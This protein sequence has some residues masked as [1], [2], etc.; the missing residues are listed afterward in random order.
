MK[1]RNLI[2]PREQRREQ[3]KIYDF[4][5]GL[6]IDFMHFVSKQKDDDPE[7]DKKADAKF[8]YCNLKWKNK[9]HDKSLAWMGLKQDAFSEN[10]KRIAGQGR[11]VGITKTGEIVQKP[12]GEPLISGE[13]IITL[14]RKQSDIILPPTLKKEL[15]NGKPDIII[16]KK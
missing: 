6:I 8:Q 12:H 4:L 13:K 5:Q 10:I 9:C 7:A 3:K 1:R 11:V 14:P 16:V 2:S 15:E